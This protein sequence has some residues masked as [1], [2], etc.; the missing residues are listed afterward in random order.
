[1][2]CRHCGTEIADR[3]LVCYRC[4]SATAEPT[5]RTGRPARRWSRIPVVAALLVLALAALF[6]AQAV[7][8]QAPRLV[9]WTVVGLAA[10][11]L[12]WQ[13]RRGH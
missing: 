7:S 4:G 2:I 3:A 1:M 8:G 11:V 13:F 9:S 12:A 10:I 5:V 6:M